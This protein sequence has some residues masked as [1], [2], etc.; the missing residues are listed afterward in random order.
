[1]PWRSKTPD[2]FKVFYQQTI[3]PGLDSLE[4]LRKKVWEKIVI[5]TLVVFCFFIVIAAIML[6][7]A[8]V[9]QALM[10]PLV[11]CAVLWVVL[12]RIVVNKSR[13]KFIAAFKEQVIGEIVRFI[14]PGLDYNYSKYIPLS[15]FNASKIFNVSPNRYRGDDYVSGR[16]GDTQIEFSE[17][18][19]ERVT[20][21]IDSK[22]RTRKEVQTIFKGL[23]FIAD[24]N[25]EFKGT[26]VLLPDLTQK[27]LGR[28]AQ[29]IQSIFRPRG[30]LIKLEDPDFEKRY[31]VYGDDQVEARYIL[32]PGLMRRLV[33][34]W[35]KM[36]KVNDSI[37]GNFGSGNVNFLSNFS[38]VRMVYLSFIRSQVIVAIS[39]NRKLFEPRL[40]RTLLDYSTI[41]DYFD[42][43]QLAL[44]IVE[45]LNLNTR[46]W[47]KR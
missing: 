41:E 29:K 28:F 47:S 4:K 36:N 40:F 19:A 27:F 9:I 15:V 1:M 5:L 7:G 39:F 38:N 21:R 13:V 26:T 10:I 22:G 6:S 43:L 8:F 23:F 2:E 42:D 3:L 34:F 37:L 14:E 44:G 16:I 17:V 32:T 25:K 12:F 35:D 24:F 46:I 20:T 33:S 31:V 30:Q 45:D 11:I 18:A